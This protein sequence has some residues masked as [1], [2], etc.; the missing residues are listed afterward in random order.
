MALRR[1]PPLLPSLLFLALLA[2]VIERLVV[3]DLEALETWSQDCADALNME[4]AEA[5]TALLSEDFSYKR[6]NREGGVEL[7]LRER[8]Q[9]KARAIE[10]TLRQIEVNGDVARAEARI[11][12]TISAGRIPLNA[13]LEFERGPDG[14]VLLNA[15]LTGAGGF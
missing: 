11:F 15:E 9:Y 14:W 13:R 10:I 7:A 2:F 6:H 4:N 1:R 5:L 3:T 12:A 8:K